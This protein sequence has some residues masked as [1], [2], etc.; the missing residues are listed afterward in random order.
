KQQLSR[1]CSGRARPSNAPRSTAL[2]QRGGGDTTRLP[3]GVRGGEE[4]PD[5][6][7]DC[8]TTALLRAVNPD[9]LSA[10]G[11]APPKKATTALAAG[12]VIADRYELVRELG[13]GGIG[14]VWLARNIRV[15][16]LVAIKTIHP[17]WASDDH[18]RE[19][20]KGEALAANRAAHSNIVQVFDADQTEVGD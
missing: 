16:K 4:G 13:R 8:G 9:R 3:V 18:I 20:F 2:R 19:R 15:D 1:R 10:V 12:S 7:T 17:K 5:A 14:E 6:S 11:A